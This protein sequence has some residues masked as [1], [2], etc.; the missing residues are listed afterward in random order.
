MILAKSS[1]FLTNVKW[2][3]EMTKKYKNQTIKEV[4]NVVEYCLVTLDE[5]K[6][7]G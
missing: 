2:S 4:K 5:L 6:F 1:V 3:L 7:P